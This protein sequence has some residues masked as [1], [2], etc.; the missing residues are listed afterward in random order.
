MTQ[1]LAILGGTFDPIHIG[2]LAIAEDVCYAIRAERVLFVPAA[3]QPLK[4]QAHRASPEDRLTMVQRAV[5]DNPR[6]TVSD[7]EIRRGGLSYTVD[8]IRE[9][10]T[11]APNDEL[12]FIAGADAAVDLLRWVQVERLLE[13][14]RIVI[15]QRPGTILDLAQ[16]FTALPFARERVIFVEGPA[17][18]ISASEVRQ[19]LA[20]GRPVRY[21]LPPA[22]YQY[23]QEHRLYQHADA[24]DS[25]RT[26]G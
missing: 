22:V 1:R 26:A 6:F 5:A 15:V 20:E 12:F 24:T 9:L 19:R 13:M 3:H 25:T 10:R 8:T 14:C 21:H 2:H 17:L 11:S 16:L 7:I 18:T 4:A 23:I